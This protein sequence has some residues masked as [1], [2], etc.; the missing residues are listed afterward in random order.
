MIVLHTA[1][2]PNGRKISIALEEL[3]LPYEVRSV[4]LG[5]EAQ[6]R[7]EFLALNPNHKIPVLEDDGLVIWESG[8]ILLHLAEKYG[9]LLPKDPAGRMA[10]I[11]YAFFQTGGIGPNLGRLAAQIRRPEAERN[12]EMI[13]IFSG[14][15]DRLLGVLDRILEDGREYLAGEYSI[16]DI[17]HVGWLHPMLNLKAPMLMNRPRVVDWLE[18]IIAR[19][20]VQR[21]LAVPS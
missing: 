8:A 17:M 4:N 18:R 13:E 9:G 11:Q 6:L 16:G 10:A 7:P 14:E 21:G 15:M 19:P 2:T 1:A 5:E 3:D 20:A 12:Q